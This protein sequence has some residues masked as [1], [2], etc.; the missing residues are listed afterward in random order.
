MPGYDSQRWVFTLNNWKEADITALNDLYE[1]NRFKWIAWR[2]EIGAEG[3]PHLQG[4]FVT[5]ERC[6]RGSI[7]G[8]KKDGWLSKAIPNIWAQS[9]KGTPSQSLKYMT[10]EETKAGELVQLGEMPRNK[11]EQDQDDLERLDAAAKN[12]EDLTGP[13]WFRMEAVHRH[14][15]EKR[16]LTSMM[17][18]AR[19]LSDTGYPEVYWL[20]GSTGCG[21]TS[22]AKSMAKCLSPTYFI[23]NPYG[24]G[25][26]PWW[27]GYGGEKAVI[28]DDVDPKWINLDTMKDYTDRAR[29]SRIAIKGATTY[30]LAEHI[31]ITCVQTA[32]DLY[33]SEELNRRIRH[34]FKLC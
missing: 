29:E 15:F 28:I 17:Q 18:Q 26:N 24:N 30:L 23:L 14:F 1:A 5:A 34:T 21:K 33:R 11:G 12:G 27:D 3:T 10:K 20:Y 13:E 19:L 9:M 6:P 22:T 32:A 2:P 16:R 8:K 7:L 31:I 25:T 4:A